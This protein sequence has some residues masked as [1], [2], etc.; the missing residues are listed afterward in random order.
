VIIVLVSLLEREIPGQ[1][2]T[3]FAVASKGRSI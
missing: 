1:S 2:N 3:A